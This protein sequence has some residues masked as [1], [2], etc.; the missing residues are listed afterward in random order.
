MRPRLMRDARAPAD[1]AGR[2]R[3]HSRTGQQSA[4]RG[5]GRRPCAA[6]GTQ[7]SAPTTAPA[8]GAPA[9]AVA[10]VSERSQRAAREGGGGC[11][12]WPKVQEVAS[13]RVTGARVAQQSLGVGAALFRSIGCP[14][15]RRARLLLELLQA[16]LVLAA[17]ERS[18]RALHEQPLLEPS[19]A[20]LLPLC[21]NLLP[22]PEAPCVDVDACEK[23]A[24]PRRR[25]DHASKLR[26]PLCGS[27]R[28]A[29]FS[30]DAR[31][32]SPT[33]VTM[34]RQ[35]RQRAEREDSKP[36]VAPGSTPTPV[37]KPPS[38][39]PQMPPAS[40]WCIGSSKPRWSLSPRCKCSSR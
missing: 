10:A 9:T 22:A 24:R 16:T 40:M 7:G 20:L 38:P 11:N 34:V 26:P 39:Y 2:Q 5:P 12:T 17:R 32:A 14:R 28:R 30:A 19:P 27:R 35:G 33:L 23:G 31:V 13:A 1:A 25:P 18:S 15:C 36:L 21:K 37:A 29:H 6:A 3:P 8:C 4:P